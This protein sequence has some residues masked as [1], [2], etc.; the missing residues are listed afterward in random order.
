[1]FVFGQLPDQWT[2]I[3]TAIIVAAGLYT[4]RRGKAKH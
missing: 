1:Y 2:W 4:L 3:G